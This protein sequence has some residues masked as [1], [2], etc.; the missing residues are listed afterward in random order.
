[1]KSGKSSKHD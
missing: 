1:M